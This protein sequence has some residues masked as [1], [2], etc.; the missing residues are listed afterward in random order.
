MP[1]SSPQHPLYSHQAITAFFVLSLMLSQA[2]FILVA[3]MPEE[4]R[5]LFTIF[6]AFETFIATIVVIWRHQGWAA[7]RVWVNE[8]RTWFFW[9]YVHFY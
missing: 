4:H 5:A 8:S 2:F 7:L 6:G 9:F 1:A 3:T